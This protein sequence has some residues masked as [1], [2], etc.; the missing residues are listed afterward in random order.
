MQLKSQRMS[1]PDLFDRDEPDNTRREEYDNGQIRA[2]TGATRRHQFVVG[3]LY[4]HAVNQAPHHCQIFLPGMDVQIQRGRKFYLPDVFGSCDPDDQEDRY[5][6][7]P[8]FII[9]V[10]SPST[11]RKD[12]NEKCIAYLSLKSLEQYVVVAQDRMSIEVYTPARGPWAPQ[13]ILEQPGDILEI[14]CVDLRL[15]LLDIYDGVKLP[16]LEVR[17]PGWDVPFR[18]AV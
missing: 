13:A 1:E 10:L 12:R 8:C 18:I 11:R 5:V 6:T 3:N 14:P 9:E 16:P 17:D 4:W 15:P 2:M 7:S